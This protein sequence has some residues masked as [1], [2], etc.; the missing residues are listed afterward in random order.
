MLNHGSYSRVFNMKQKGFTL[1]ELLVVVAIIGILAAVG[2]TAFKGF[3]GSAKKE[4]AE[5]NC[6]LAKNYIETQLFRCNLGNRINAFSYSTGRIDVDG[7]SIPPFRTYDTSCSQQSSATDRFQADWGK[8]FNI[9]HETSTNYAGVGGYRVHIN[10]FNAD[11]RVFQTGWDPP[12]P[13]QP[14]RTHCNI[15]PTNADVVNCHCRWGT[16]SN[17]YNTVYIRNPY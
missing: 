8:P 15:M 6:H 1:I 11:D 3:I 9:L 10:A 7:V 5:G 16:G 12:L 4:V 2:V 13:S 17:D 14:G